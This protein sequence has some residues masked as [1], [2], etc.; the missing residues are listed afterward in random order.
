[1]GLFCHHPHCPPDHPKARPPRWR[2]AQLL[3]MALKPKH[4]QWPMQDDRELLAMS[5]TD[6]TEA[7]GPGTGRCHLKDPL[8]QGT[9]LIQTRGSG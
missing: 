6:A 1:V 4:R 9:L 8:P 7:I 5:K 2:Q 3:F